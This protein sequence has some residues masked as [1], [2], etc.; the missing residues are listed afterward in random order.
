MASA[1]RKNKVEERIEELHNLLDQW[2]E[3]RLTARDP[4]EQLRS[5]KEIRKIKGYLQE[6]EEE[7]SGKRGE[8]SEDQQD[9]VIA[10]SIRA[11]NIRWI[12]GISIFAIISVISFMIIQKVNAVVPDYSAYLAYVEEGDQYTENNKFNEARV[13]YKKA[14]EYNPEDSIVL[15]KLELLDQ[16]DAYV[17]QGE[18]LKAKNTFEL[19]LTIPAA[20]SLTTVALDMLGEKPTDSSSLGTTS[21]Q[22]SNSITI[23]IS[24]AGANIVLKISGGQPFQGS[25]VDPY[26]IQGVD[27]EGCINWNK[28]EGGY[29]ASFPQE[30]MPGLKITVKDSISNSTDQDIGMPRAVNNQTENDPSAKEELFQGYLDEADNEFEQENFQKAK[31]AYIN[32]LGIKPNDKHCKERLATCNQELDKMALAAAKN[33]GRKSIAGGTFEMGVDGGFAIEGPKHSVNVGAFKI[34]I[35]EVTVAQYKAYCKFTGK[36]MP[37]APAWGWIDSH[38]MVNVTWNEAK[39]YCQWLGG[40]LPTEAEWEFAASERKGSEGTAY[41]GSNSLKGIAIYKENSSGKTS[42][43]KS[44]KANSLGLY[45]MTGNASEWCNDWYSGRYYKSSPAAN[46]KGPNSGTRRVIRGGSY[47]AIPNSINDGDQLKN[48]YRN[49]KDPK[50]RAPNIGFRVAW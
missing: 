7:L 22:P 49:Y 33:I 19:I 46:P 42:P 44:K 45:D 39:A 23:S 21:D 4:N 47:E 32:A 31:E 18:H 11:N 12:I 35:T 30:K 37:T 40:R 41:S 15:K 9:P 50:T 36:S 24:F 28:I 2:E 25:Q 43:V 5:E 29:Q 48:T 34:S 17:E 14:L 3:V 13:S 27:C 6:Y 1:N 16:A 26:Y 20:S 8:V 10:P 38:P